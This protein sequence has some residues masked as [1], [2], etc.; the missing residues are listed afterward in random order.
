MKEFL[1][2]VG[3]EHI[4]FAILACAVLAILWSLER[5]SNDRASRF[6][7]DELLTE[8]GKTSKAAC[9]MFGS[10]AVATWLIVFLTVNGKITEGYF[11]AYLGF[12]VAPAV[13]RIIKGPDATNSS[14]V[15]T[16][17]SSTVV[18]K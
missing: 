10:F 8:D 16:I 14:T 7:F 12:Y 2:A 3:R 18:E 6:S 1:Q 13:A 9:L 17:S 15:S 11:T 5:K 4:M